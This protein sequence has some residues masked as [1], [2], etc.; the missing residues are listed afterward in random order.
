MRI[1]KRK[2]RYSVVYYFIGFSLFAFGIMV[3]ALE[4]LHLGQSQAA[5]VE[6]SGP[7][8]SISPRE[9]LYDPSLAQQYGVNGLVIINLSSTADANLTAEPGQTLTV[10]LNVSFISYTPLYPSVSVA[11]NPVAGQEMLGN[12]DISSLESYSVSSSNLSTSPM[13]TNLLIHIPAV[14]QVSSF[15]VSPMGIEVE[16]SNGILVYVEAKIMVNISN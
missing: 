1:G 7:I 2:S 11:F 10:P 14:V 4:V 15:Q 9:L 13:L 6:P 5:N 16:P 3:C 12:F 8:G